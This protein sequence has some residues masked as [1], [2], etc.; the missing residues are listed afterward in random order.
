MCPISTAVSMRKGAPQFGTGFSGGYA[1]QV[2][3]SGWLEGFA[4]RDV[5]D[6]VVL[7]V[8]AGNQVAPS[9]E[10]F[11]DE[12]ERLVAVAE[13]PLPTR[14][15]EGRESRRGMEERLD[16]LFGH[17]TSFFAADRRAEF[18]LVHLVIAAKKENHRAQLDLAG[19]RVGFV[20]HQR[21]RLHLVFW[22]HAEEFRDVLNRLHAGRVDFKRLAVAFGLEVFDRCRSST[23]LFP[24]WRRSHT[25]R[26]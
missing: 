4:G 6:V 20:R 22:R 26:S 16:F 18:C 15:S 3:V 17:G 9:F 2:D 12:E 10:G 25:F 14:H 24:G 23:W 11:V 7:F 5:L 8:G 1:S 13:S 21:E 19:F